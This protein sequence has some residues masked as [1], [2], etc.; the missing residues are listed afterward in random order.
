MFDDLSRSFDI[1]TLAAQ[2]GKSLEEKRDM[3]VQQQRE[4]AITP[5]AIDDPIH[6][7]YHPQVCTI[8]PH[9][10]INTTC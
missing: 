2:P 10:C 6:N 7:V 5:P 3:V 8:S 1:R 9:L 4:N